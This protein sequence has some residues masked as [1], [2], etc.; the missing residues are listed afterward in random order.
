MTIKSAPL[1]QKT[2]IL[3]LSAASSI[4]GAV[5]SLINLLKNIDYNLYD[6]FVLI[7]S[8]ECKEFCDELS[9]INVVQLQE[10]MRVNEWLS[11]TLK[12]VH[13]SIN[14]WHKAKAPGRFLRHIINAYKIANLI[15]EQQIDIVHTND[16]I[17]IDGALGALL[18]KRPHIWHIRSRLGSSGLLTHFLGLNFILR[19]ISLLSYKVIVNSKETLIPWKEKGVTGNVTLIHNGVDVE[20][21]SNTVGKLRAEYNIAN[22]VP[23]IAMITTFPEFD[24]LHNF[25]DVAIQV[26]K[27]QPTAQFIVIGK[28]DTCDQNYMTQQKLKLAEKMIDNKFIFTGFRR[29]LPQLFPDIDIL[30]EPMQN[31]SW[32]RVVLEAMAAGVAIIAVED[33]RKS[34]FLT[35]NETGILAR[36]NQEIFESIIY[37]L[38]NQQIR[39]QMSEKAKK[40]VNENYTNKLYAAK[41]MKIYEECISGKS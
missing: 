33:D 40:H 4:G 16:E 15:R 39:K 13:A 23:I 25:I 22:D 3:Y 8:D 5:F 37:L 7:T 12:Q 18:A 29:D 24:G 38:N 10:K 34:D 17:L 27:I 1:P 41:V 28:T 35:H 6:A 30:I 26:S 11:L 19:I 2:R 32:S 20:L 9:K 36:N 21:F 14:M 31:G